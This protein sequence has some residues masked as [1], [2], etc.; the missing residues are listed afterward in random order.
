MLLSA[1]EHLINV[2]AN[3]NALDFFVSAE[4][5]TMPGS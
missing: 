3:K 2:D 5:S 1:S 4:P